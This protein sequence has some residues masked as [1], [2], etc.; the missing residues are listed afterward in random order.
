MTDILQYNYIEVSNADTIDKFY[1]KII[2]II[3]I[4]L[5]QLIIHRSCF[6]HNNS[7]F[8]TLYQNKIDL[9]NVNTLCVHT[10]EARI[11]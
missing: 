11:I 4:Y 1:G 10:L 7:R 8:I 6:G 3:L 2:I 9:I 5:Y